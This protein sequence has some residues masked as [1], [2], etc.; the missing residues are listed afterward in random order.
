MATK[1]STAEEV[2]NRIITSYMSYVLEQEASPKSVYNFCKE[3]K[4]AEDAFYNHF[5][6]VS[7]IQEAIWNQF[8]VN[9]ENLLHKNKEYEDF[10]NKDKML[11]FYFTFF[12]LLK[13]NRS[14]VLFVLEEGKNNIAHLKQ[15]KGLRRRVKDFATELIETNNEKKQFKFSQNNPMIFSEGA[16]LQLVFL[17]QFWKNDTSAS[18][19]KTD[20][21]IEKSVRSIFDVFDN[22]PLDSVLDFGKFLIKE[23]FG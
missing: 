18:F 17:M 3:K 11:S 8:F 5:G 13:L 1:K 23:N 7:G 22:T 4:V 21:A 12:E 20:I 19:E 6:S 10:S 16:W 15:M 9:T 14:Y 2:K